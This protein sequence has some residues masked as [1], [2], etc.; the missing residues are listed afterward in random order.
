[1]LRK[2]ITSVGN[3]KKMHQDLSKF[4]NSVSTI[5]FKLC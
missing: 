1:M 2:Q 3:N 5:T 4:K